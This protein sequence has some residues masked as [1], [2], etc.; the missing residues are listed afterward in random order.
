VAGALLAIGLALLEAGVLFTSDLSLAARIGSAIAIFAMVGT[1]VLF[2]NHAVA[3]YSR[4]VSCWSQLGCLLLQRR[5]ALRHFW[6][7]IHGNLPLPA[8]TV[9]RVVFR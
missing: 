9:S 6:C 1:V 7:A 3:Q 4:W 5:I 2:A 8:R